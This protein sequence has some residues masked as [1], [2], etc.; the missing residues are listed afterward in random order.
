MSR[1][2]WGQ[3]FLVDESLAKR[4]CDAFI[5][6]GDFGEIGPGSGAL[7]KHL[8][9]RFSHFSLFEIDP[10][11]ADFHRKN[12][13]LEIIEGD[14]LNWNFSKMGKAVEDFS[15]IGNLPYESGSEMMKRIALNAEKISHFVFMLQKEVCERLTAEPKSRDFSSFTV[16]VRGQFDIQKVVDIPARAFSPPPKVESQ[17][18]VG[19]RRTIRHSLHDSYLRFLRVAFAQKRKTLRNNLKPFPYDYAALKEAFGFSDNTRAEEIAVDLWPEIFK[20]T[21][22]A[23]GRG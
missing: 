11:W 14:F 12:S 18:I 4:I 13:S 16:M 21:C 15:L 5:P 17:V 23:H 3:H 7:T 8:L 19:T 2:K 10:Q 1:Q 22:T 9:T 20:K 6:T